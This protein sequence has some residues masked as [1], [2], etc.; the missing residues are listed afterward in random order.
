M[1]DQAASADHE[2]L[3]DVQNISKSFGGVKALRDVSVQFRAGEV[4]ALLGENGAGKSTLVK[5]IAGVYV[6]D[7]GEVR[8]AGG[9]TARDVAMVFQEL[10][11]LPDLSV[12]DNLAISLRGK[13][14]LLVGRRR[15]DQRV[16]ELLEMA[17]LGDVDPH[18]PVSVLTLAQRQLLEIAR[19]LAAD[20]RTLILDEPTA[21]LSDA[22][23][24]RVHGVVR[25]LTAEGRAIVY[26][27]HRMGEVFALS[28]RITV[29]RSGQVV[30]TGPTSDFTMDGI[31]SD[32]LGEEVAAHLGQQH[33]VH[34]PVDGSVVVA[35]RLGSGRRFQS[36]DF[37]AR[38]GRVT[39]FFGQIGSGADD[40][41][42]AVA[43]L[44][45]VTDGSLTL[46]GTEL[47]TRD[48]SRSQRAGVAYVSPDRVLEGVFLAGTV[49]RNI[50]S[51]TLDT[52]STAGVISSRAEAHLARELAPRVAFDADRIETPVG[53]LSGGNQQKI[54]IARALA[55]RPTVLV[56]NEPTRGVDIGARAG[57]Y[58]AL[59][60]LAA[61]GVAVVVYTS[62]I[63]EVRELADEVVTMF[64]GRPV[65]THA[66]AD[67]TD[68]EILADIL[69][70]SAA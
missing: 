25:S 16:R 65:S 47:P 11:V 1:T 67:V 38:A 28:H 9:D 63:V 44:V 21:T 15:V 30:A 31:V 39:A 22:E 24:A 41:V 59:R 29:M 46:D 42:R 64:R 55:T 26:I 10:S 68:A 14:S 61:E 6:A 50:S 56:L 19:G 27:T 66:L 34:A 5:I 18:L 48:R 58:Q 57:I 36:V 35:S 60:D 17:G 51:G 69:Q 2:V 45:P 62:D 23:I 53:N 33:T 4:H 13:R 52:V 20:A 43:G 7:A 3:L 49:T 37:E 40:V 70:G 12:R 8:T 54:A 32:M